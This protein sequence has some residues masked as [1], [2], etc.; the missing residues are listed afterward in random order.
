MKPL[1]LAAITLIVTALPLQGA[2]FPLNMTHQNFHHGRAMLSP[3]G[4]WVS[5]FE[6][7][8]D[9]ITWQLQHVESHQQY[10]LFSITENLYSRPTTIDRIYWVDR[11]TLLLQHRDRG[12]QRFRLYHYEPQ[13]PDHPWRGNDLDESLHLISAQ[14]DDEDHVLIMAR[15]P[16]SKGNA[17]YRVNINEP[18]EP[19]LKDK[20]LVSGELSYAVLLTADHN[21]EVRLGLIMRSDR[22]SL[23]FRVSSDKPWRYGHKFSEDDQPMKPIGFISPERI[24]VLTREGNGTVGVYAYDLD[25]KSLAEPLYQLDG[26]DITDASIDA[27]GELVAVS[28]YQFGQLQIRYLQSSHQSL[29]SEVQSELAGHQVVLADRQH[30]TDLLAVFSESR[31]GSVYLRRN[32]TLRK[33]FDQ[34]PQL[35]PYQFFESEVFTVTRPDGIEIEA[36]LMRP[37]ASNGVLLVMPHGGP[38]GI[39][40]DRNFNP[41]QQYFASRGYSTLRVN[42]RGSGG[43]GE[44]FMELGVGEQGRE[45]EAD[46]QAVVEQVQARYQFP[47]RCAF[48]TS[49]GGYSAIALTIQNPGFYHCAISGFGLSDLSFIYNSSNF[50]VHGQLRGAIE[51]TYGDAPDQDMHLRPRSLI[52]QAENIE[53]P[54]LLYAGLQDK[55]VDIEHFHRLTMQLD[56]LNKPYSTVLFKRSGHGHDHWTP[57]RL[58]LTMVD[59]FIRQQL[60]LAPPSTTEDRLILADEV[61]SLGYQYRIGVWLDKNPELTRELY[62]LA[63]DLGSVDAIANLGFMYDNALGGIGSAFKAFSLYQEAHEKGSRLGT[64]NLADCLYEGRYAD[65]DKPRAIEMMRQLQ[66]GDDWVAKR[67]GEYLESWNL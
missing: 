40:D 38:I 1:L 8:G 28:F 4:Q 54:L 49:Y 15:R 45:I 20:N 64:L 42:Y 12:N 62:Q 18:I 52:R 56:R 60:N 2:Y 46:I 14:P 66:Q 35:E 55:T 31:P 9:K 29:V 22:L 13:N 26:L 30:G 11:T 25:K 27:D 34:Q 5:Y 23:V 7:Q 32:G 39:Q 19:Q 43:K 21:G 17:A 65:Q 3:D 44:P 61:M 67:A 53:V 16:A 58:E 37:D 33:L 59:Q 51:R 41:D 24:A 50:A 57:H 47:H 10:P 36:F 6:R 48:G 63:I